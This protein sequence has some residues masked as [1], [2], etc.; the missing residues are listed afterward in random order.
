MDVLYSLLR[1]NNRRL[2]TIIQENDFASVLNFVL[3]S[4]FNATFASVDLR[5]DQFCTSY[6]KTSL[7]QYTADL[8]GHVLKFFEDLKYLSIIGL[9]PHYYP[10]LVLSNVPSTTFFSST[11]NKLCI[12]VRR[13]EDCLALIDGRLKQLTILIIV[14]ENME[15][16][17]SNV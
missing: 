1:V 10:S 5:V 16:A 8:Y 3:T 6:M 15:Y 14:I 11:L 13:F 2:D 9:Y 17:S 7:K 12:R 4:S